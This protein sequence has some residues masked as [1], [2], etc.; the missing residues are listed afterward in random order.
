MVTQCM[1]ILWDSYM[2]LHVHVAMTEREALC[3]V[4][5]TRHMYVGTPHAREVVKGK[6][7]SYRGPNANT[8][9]SVYTQVKLTQWHIQCTVCM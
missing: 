1:Y 5:R 6:L 4:Q 3:N 7:V 8:Q 2:Y 9:L